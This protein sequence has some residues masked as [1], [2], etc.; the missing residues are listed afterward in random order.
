MGIKFGIIAMGMM[1]HMN[2]SPIWK[3]GELAKSHQ[4][5]NHSI[6]PFRSGGIMT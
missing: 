4:F 2:H 3:A 1:N 5:T 6:Q